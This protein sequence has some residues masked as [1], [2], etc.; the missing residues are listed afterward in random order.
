VPLPKPLYL[1]RDSLLEPPTRAVTAAAAAA[2]S[3]AAA[4]ADQALRSVQASPKV[5]TIQPRAP[6]PAFAALG[7]DATGEPMLGD[8][9]AVLR[10]RRAS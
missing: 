9:D 6:H 1:E 7:I 5:A 4:E 3:A 2:L 8:L 10:R